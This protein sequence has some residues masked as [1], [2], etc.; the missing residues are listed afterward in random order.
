V[1]QHVHQEILGLDAFP[2]L[3]PV[4]DRGRGFE[5]LHG[6]GEHPPGFHGEASYRVALATLPRH[7]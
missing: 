6:A 5:P 2:S 1:T 7:G 4:I 3:L